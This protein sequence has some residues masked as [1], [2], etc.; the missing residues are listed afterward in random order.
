MENAADSPL[1]TVRMECASDTEQHEIRSD[2]HPP[3]SCRSSVRRERSCGVACRNGVGISGAECTVGI[4]VGSYSDDSRDVMHQGV[5]SGQNLKN[6]SNAYND[7]EHVG[8]HDFGS[9][10]VQGG[11][12]HGLNDDSVHGPGRILTLPEP[13]QPYGS[14]APSAMFTHAGD[15]TVRH[16]V[17][18]PHCLHPHYLNSVLG[19][20]R[21]RQDSLIHSGINRAIAG[22]GFSMQF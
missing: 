1:S 9:A 11:E 7:S 2:A 14:A 21:R 17:F 4:D 5:R 22:D 16:G 6:C 18:Q 3:C 15:E 12:Q 20:Y 13:V 10:G 8:R 19:R